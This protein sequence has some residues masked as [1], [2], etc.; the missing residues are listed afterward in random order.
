ME[1]TKNLNREEINKN[2][3]RTLTL[4]RSTKPEAADL[5][6]NMLNE[7][8]L[9]RYGDSKQA[10]DISKFSKLNSE[11][12]NETKI[13]VS[14]KKS[15]LKKT[16]NDQISKNETNLNELSNGVGIQDIHQKTKHNL[17]KLNNK[18]SKHNKSMTKII[19]DVKNKNNCFEKAGTPIDE[20]D[21]EITN[22]TPQLSTTIP[23]LNNKTKSNIISKQN[24]NGENS[25]GTLESKINEIQNT[26]NSQPKKEN[27]SFGL[28]PIVKRAPLQHKCTVKARSHK[29]PPLHELSSRQ[30]IQAVLEKGI[31]NK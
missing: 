15:K 11:K 14:N 27:E 12:N 31:N 17:K 26:E 7:S 24:E 13:K 8:I 25:N 20:Y 21:E 18:I 29:K 5:M 28:P 22:N 30:R 10:I 2:C 1:I 4:L 16:K 19:K 23:H 6:L 9:K 3:E